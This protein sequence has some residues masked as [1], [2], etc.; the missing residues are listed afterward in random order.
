VAEVVREQATGLAACGH[1]VTVVTEFDPCRATM[2]PLSGVAIREFKVKADPRAKAGASGE[3][4]DYQ[5]FVAK[6][7]VDVILC[8]CW[9][10]W[11]TDLAIPVFRRNRARKIF[12]S[13]GFATH[14]WNRQRR[15]PWGLGR[16][17]CQW[18]QVWQSPRKMRTFDHIVFLSQRV[19]RRRF[20]DH[21]LLERFGGPEWSVIPNG[22]WPERFAENRMDF[23]IQHGL[24]D[25]FLI[26]NVGLYAVTK[27]QET[28][29]RSFSESG[30]EGAALVFI[31]NELND[32]AGQLRQLAGRLPFGGG[33]SVLFLEKQD[34]ENIRAAYQAADLFLLTSKGETQPLVLLDAMACGRP[35]VS[36][37]VGC[38]S[39]LPGG[40]TVRYPTELVRT[41]RALQADPARLAA[42][43]QRGLAA[44]RSTYHWPNI[45]AAYDRL[46]R[47]VAT[48]QT[49]S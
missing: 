5:D 35:F 33:S 19:D 32:Y 48:Q 22:T 8:H 9:G 2:E 42:L 1:E 18:P 3:V 16:W 20:F 44:A 25:Q 45:V 39:E 13:H 29:L 41:L 17:F 11:P 31:G 49:R 24:R 27:G 4:T 38:V 7:D 12:V 40:V 6:A 47:A 10:A 26:L 34:R 46:I 14:L 23:R 30:I 43:G 36:T 15:F 37:D 28:A 21:W